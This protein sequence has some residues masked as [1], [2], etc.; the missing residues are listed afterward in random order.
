ME[1]TPLFRSAT[2]HSLE[3]DRRDK[4]SAA[5]SLKNYVTFKDWTFLNMNSCRRRI[6]Q[7]NNR[8]FLTLAACLLLPFLT[9]TCFSLLAAFWMLYQKQNI[10]WSC[11][12]QA[13]RSQKHLIDG[14]EGILRLNPQVEALIFQKRTVLA[15]YRAA[16][17]PAQKAALKIML[18]LTIL[19]M[20]ILRQAQL[21]ILRTAEVQAQ[22][23]LFRPYRPVHSD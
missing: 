23:A 10:Q 1:N 5:V 8:G 16:I 17:V 11:Q 22:V 9:L 18:E 21:S 19:E 3:L 15:A 4:C 12:T 7:K 2:S 6:H 13:L 20:K 14:T